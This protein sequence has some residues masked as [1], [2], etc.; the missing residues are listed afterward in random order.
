MITILIL[1]LSL[2]SCSSDDDQMPPDNT[3]LIRDNFYEPAQLTITLGRSVVWRN[4]GST[5]HTA[6]S[7]TPVSNP[8]TLFDSGTIAP[9][10]GFTFTFSQPGTYVYFCRIHGAG[11]SGTI[12]VQ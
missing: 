8:G 9:G 3:I 11:M 7:G 5:S 2:V 6:T 1:S 12:V 4:Q 10:G